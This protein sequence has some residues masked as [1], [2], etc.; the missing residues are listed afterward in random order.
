[1]T[2]TSLPPQNSI[3]FAT[4]VTGLF[5]RYFTIMRATIAA[6]ILTLAINPWQIV[7]NGGSF[8]NFIGAYPAFLAPVAMIMLV[9]WFAVRKGNVDIR[10]LYNPKGPFA[11]T[12]GFNWRAY[13]AWI[14]SLAPNLPVRSMLPADAGE[15]PS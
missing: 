4:D 11:Y 14:I 2:L 15:G 9:D 1:M 3:S 6:G 8:F 12:Y 7:N 5:P 10:D 13:A